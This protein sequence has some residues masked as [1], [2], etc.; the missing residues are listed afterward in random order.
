MPTAAPQTVR[1]A[2]DPM[3]ALL[4]RLLP[5][6][7][8]TF[9][10]TAAAPRPGRVRHWPGALSGMEDAGEHALEGQVLGRLRRALHGIEP[11]RSSPQEPGGW[12]L[13]V[14]PVCA[15][16]PCLAAW[17][18]TSS[19]G[20][21]GAAELELA[22]LIAPGLRQHWSLSRLRKD[23]V[24]SREIEV[25]SLVGMGL[26]AAAVARRCGISI[27]TVHKHLEH[28]YA[29]LGCHDRLSAV[30]LLRDAGLLGPAVAG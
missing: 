26:T 3:V 11:L 14:L 12:W 9:A 25:L 16:P 24:T 21:F 10:S 18:L 22:R 29:K 15:E 17:V 13:L 20:E 4:H 8:I 1:A 30:M 7:W 19:T 2:A 23:G 5:C 27:R 6:E 28:A